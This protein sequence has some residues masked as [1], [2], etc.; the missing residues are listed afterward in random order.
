MNRRLR[1]IFFM[2]LLSGPALL[3]QSGPAMAGAPAEP[4]AVDAAT[5]KVPPGMGK[6]NHI[7]FLIKENRS[8]DNYFG[9]FPGANGATTGKISTGQVFPL[10]R[11]ADRTAHDLGHS[12]DASLTAVDGGKMDQFDLIKDGTVNGDYEAYTQLT[13]Q[14]IP[15]YFAYAKQFVLS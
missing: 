11:T 1:S 6:I 12:W 14:D 5:A 2:M 8:F 7:V 13:E 15:N 3:A 10:A 9:T 4:A